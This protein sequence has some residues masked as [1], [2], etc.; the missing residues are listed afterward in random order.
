MENPT[1]SHQTSQKLVDPFLTLLSPEQ[2]NTIA[3]SPGKLTPTNVLCENCSSSCISLQQLSHAL[4]RT[5]ILQ[6]AAA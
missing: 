6:V 3:I 5:A 1:W 2:A 4:T